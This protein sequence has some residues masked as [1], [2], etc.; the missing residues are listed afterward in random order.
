ML[1]QD[2]GTDQPGA[3]VLREQILRGEGGG[4]GGL[5]GLG[6]PTLPKVVTRKI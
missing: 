1:V 2:A 4:G 5:V 6:N 3:V